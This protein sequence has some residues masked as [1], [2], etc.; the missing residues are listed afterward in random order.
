MHWPP[1][2]GWRGPLRA[3]W[4]HRAIRHLPGHIAMGKPKRERLHS[5]IR[6]RISGGRAV[7]SASTGEWCSI[8]PP[9]APPAVTR[10]YL[11]ATRSRLTSKSRFATCGASGF[12]GHT[13][14]V[15]MPSMS[16]WALRLEAHVR[17]VASS[18]FYALDV[19][20]GFATDAL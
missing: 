2:D 1:S 14:K 7:S 12:V 13:F 18:G 20:L 4:L 11:T 10:C 3:Q 17:L 5:E 6:H 9:P 19:G 15:S 8:L 16:G